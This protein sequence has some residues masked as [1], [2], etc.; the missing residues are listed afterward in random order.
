MMKSMTNVKRKLSND[1]CNSLSDYKKSNAVN[2]LKRNRLFQIKS[3][4]VL[5]NDEN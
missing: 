4:I 3:S 5:Q 2:T 1:K